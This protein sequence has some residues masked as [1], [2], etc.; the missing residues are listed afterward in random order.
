[1]I[2]RHESTCTKKSPYCKLTCD[3]Y[4]RRLNRTDAKKV[5]P[6]YDAVKRRSAIMRK[7]KKKQVKARFGR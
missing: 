4:M 3:E 5:T 1:M 2:C 6:G 7:L